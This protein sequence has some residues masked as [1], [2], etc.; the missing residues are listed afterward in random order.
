MH[1]AEDRMHPASLSLALPRRPQDGADGRRLEITLDRGRTYRLVVPDSAQRRAI[2]SQLDAC[3]IAALVPASGRL[4]ANLKVWENIVLPLAYRGAVSTSELEARAAGV[5]AEL[6]Y[7][8][9]QVR[10]LAIRL[11]D[12]LGTLERRLVAFV[13][14]ML[15][16]PE[17]LVL[18]SVADGLTRSDAARAF[19]LGAIYLRRFPFRTVVHIEPE[20]SDSADWI[21]V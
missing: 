2:V 9:E 6:G 10:D 12:Q 17:V 14:A 20:P 19:A 1:T 5:F 21:E 13:R 11:P 8:P 18:D 3:G 15:A 7:S 4:I 16:E